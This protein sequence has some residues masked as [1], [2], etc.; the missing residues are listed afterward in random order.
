MTVRLEPIGYI[1]SSIKNRRKIA[2]GRLKAQIMVEPPYEKALDGIES[3]SHVIIVFW[4]HKVKKSER[5][6]IQ[7]HPYRNPALP[8]KGVFATRS[9][10]RPNPIGLTV[11]KLIN[12]EG[13][14][15]TVE[16]LDAID[17]TPVLDI[18]P[19]IPEPFLKT[20]ISVPGWI[21][22]NRRQAT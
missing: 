13:T 5:A 10:V 7:V 14:T 12:R 19:Y 8:L 11:V 3:F 22:K 15:L 20:K 16:G 9:P 4:L 1:K 21:K 17:G 2:Y 6:I 18:K